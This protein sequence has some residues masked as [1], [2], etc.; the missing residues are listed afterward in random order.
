MAESDEKNIQLG[1]GRLVSSPE[2]ATNRLSL[3]NSIPPPDFRQLISGVPTKSFFLNNQ[4]LN[5]SYMLGTCDDTKLIV[6]NKQNMIIQVIRARGENL[7]LVSLTLTLFNN[8][9]ILT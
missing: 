3:G 1:E 9:T 4:I 7:M 6:V 2:C 5:S 8:S